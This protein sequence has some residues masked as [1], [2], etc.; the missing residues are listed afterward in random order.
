VSRVFLLC[1]KKVKSSAIPGN[2][3]DFGG[4]L[5]KKRAAKLKFA[6]IIA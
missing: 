5:A 6:Q 3:G 1:F 4:G 2:Y